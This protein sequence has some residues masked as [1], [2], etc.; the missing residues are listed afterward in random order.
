MRRAREMEIG[1]VARGG[2]GASGQATEVQYL[3]PHERTGH[4]IS[5]ALDI[6]AG[7]RIKNIESS[8][9]ASTTRPTGNQ[10]G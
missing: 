6:D 4:D 1:A 2:L 5:L 10:A 7:V 9:H 8:T 3:R